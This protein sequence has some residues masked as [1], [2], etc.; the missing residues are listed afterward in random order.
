ML[1][2]EEIKKIIPYAE[3]YLFLD[4]AE[5][6]NEN[7]IIGFYQTHPDD[8]YFKG[9]FVDYPLMPGVLI[10]EALAQLA[11]I[12]LRKNWGPDYK[13]YHF[14]AYDVRGCQFFKPTFP[15]DRIKLKA[16]ILGVYPVR[17]PNF[18]EI[19]AVSKSSS[20]GVYP[21]N[22]KTKIAHAKGQAFVDEELKC[23]GRFSV[24]IINKKE[25]SEKY[26]K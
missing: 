25:F 5:I 9:H 15:G 10:I 11:G 17:R 24:A 14:L 20:N 6:I 19:E 2:K 13:D 1:S 8:Y 23:E 4:E 18:P 22:E 26:K 7:E 3:P 16:E 21:V 12:I